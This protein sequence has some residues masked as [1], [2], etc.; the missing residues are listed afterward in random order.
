MQ[1]FQR[2]PLVGHIPASHF[3]PFTKNAHVGKFCKYRIKE[4]L[5]RR[6]GSRKARLAGT[7][8]VVM[9]SSII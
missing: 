4:R 8:G 3:T 9:E 7:V 2:P 5:H 1:V 6:P